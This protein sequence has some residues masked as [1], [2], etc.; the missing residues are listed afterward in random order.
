MDACLK[1]YDDSN[2][3]SDFGPRQGKRGG[4][5]QRP[6]LPGQVSAFD[7]AGAYRD[8][9][10]VSTSRPGDEAMGVKRAS[11]FIERSVRE[12]TEI[13]KAHP[14]SAYLSKDEQA[15]GV[16]CTREWMYRNWEI[17]G[18]FAKIF[19]GP[20]HYEI[21]DLYEEQFKKAAALHGKG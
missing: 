2:E 5:V 3:N 11:G 20:A 14:I 6:A 19:F 21:C 9:L 4:R 12:F 10:A 17:H 8:Q 7:I 1:I 16:L 15:F 18:R 13:M